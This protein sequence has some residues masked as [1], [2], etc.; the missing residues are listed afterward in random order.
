[1]NLIKLIL[2][3]LEER[4]GEE[5][6]VVLPPS[7]FRGHSPEEVDGHLRLILE[8]GLAKGEF[9]F[10]GYQIYSLTWEG[11]DFLD[12]SRNS[13]VWNAA[14]KAAGGLSFGVFQKV[15]EAAATGVAMKALGM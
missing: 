7:L 1:M 2:E 9:S 13:E 8:R 14:M 15:L 5:R 4:C 11:H 3:Q 10:G 12:N 6:P